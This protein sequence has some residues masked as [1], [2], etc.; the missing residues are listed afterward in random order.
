LAEH[1]REVSIH[2]EV[3]EP[4]GLYDGIQRRR[5]LAAAQAAKEQITLAADRHRPQ[6][7]FQVVRELAAAVVEEPRECGA[8]V[9]GVADRLGQLRSTTPN[10]RADSGAV[11]LR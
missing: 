1:V 11:T 4:R 10:S 2:I 5:V 7:A 8:A 3:I 6:R 9:Q